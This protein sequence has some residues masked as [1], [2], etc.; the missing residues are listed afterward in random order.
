MGK[1]PIVG[2]A[3]GGGGLRGAAHIGILQELES[4]GIPIHMVAG[5]SA[6]SVIAAMYATGMSPQEMEKVA[7]SLKPSAILDP[8]ISLLSASLMF[9]KV[10]FDLINLPTPWG[11]FI[12]KGFIKGQRLSE[13]IER[14]TRGKGF[15]QTDIPLAIIAVDIYTGK[16]IVFA[17]QRNHS[18][19]S[20]NYKRNC[21][22]ITDEPIW[23]AARASSAIPGIFEAQKVKDMDLVDGAIKNNVPADI[24]KVLGADY[25]IAVDLEFSSQN[26]D[27]MDNLLEIM[28]QTT[29]IM[30]QTLTDLKLKLY[31]DFIIRPGIQ[32]MKLTDVNK[33]PQC[34]KAGRQAAKRLVPEIMRVLKQ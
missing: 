30:G 6:G 19:L 16:E 3:L 14:K 15:E 28:L 1:Q 32:D 5:T 8:N 34:I 12:P 17:S 24:L 21:V 31:G 26:P 7:L 11:S 33:I 22:Y 18:L 10:I 23:K 9:L 4:A 2:L 20:R 25:V 13:F 29:D 27:K